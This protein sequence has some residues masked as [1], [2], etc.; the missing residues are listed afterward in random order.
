[1]HREF[2]DHFGADLLSSDMVL[3]NMDCRDSSSIPRFRAVERIPV[4]EV[5]NIR[6]PCLAS[7]IPE[8]FIRVSRPVTAR[9]IGFSISTVC[10]P[11]IAMPASRF[12]LCAGQD[13]LQYA[14]RQTIAGKTTISG[15]RLSHHAI[16]SLT[17]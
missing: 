2:L 3:I 4:R 12:R 17:E 5:V 1:V 8:D 9:R 7:A 13:F 6:H 10:P 11:M 16:I 14:H 15:N